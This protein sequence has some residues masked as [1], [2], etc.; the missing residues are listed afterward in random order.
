MSL[1]TKILFVWLI[2]SFLWLDC[3]WWQ[4]VWEPI[5]AAFGLQHIRLHQGPP[6]A[7]TNE[8]VD[9]N[10]Q[11]CVGLNW[12]WF[13]RIWQQNDFLLVV[14]KIYKV[15]RNIVS[16]CSFFPL[17]YPVLYCTML[18]SAQ[19]EAEKEKIMNKMEADQDLSK[20]LY[21][22]QET[23]KEDIIRVSTSPPFLVGLVEYEI[24]LFI[25]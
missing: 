13:L 1:E 24:F 2:Y 10:S 12:V 17:P 3:Q 11:D 9:H 14:F 8:W 22:L 7:Q 23:E 20:V 4:R 16:C 6:A 15:F 18:A 19:S 5:G 21:Q 25:F